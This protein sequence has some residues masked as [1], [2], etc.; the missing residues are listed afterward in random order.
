MAPINSQNNV[1]SRSGR[2]NATLHRCESSDASLSNHI[3]GGNLVAG[4]IRRQSRHEYEFAMNRKI[5]GC[6]NI[7]SLTLTRKA[8]VVNRCYFRIAQRPL[9]KSEFIDLTSEKTLA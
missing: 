6:P 9:V 4:Y 5:I 3:A 2:I 8:G 1:R 7:P